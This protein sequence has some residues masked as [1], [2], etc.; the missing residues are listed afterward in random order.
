MATI[1]LYLDSRAKETD[2]SIKLA[3]THHGST[4]YIPTGIRVNKDQWDKAA[5]KIINHPRKTQL[6][7]IL[8]N[9]RYRATESLAT[10][11]TRVRVNSLTAT[12]LR[13]LVRDI[14][15][16]SGQQAEG[17]DTF[18]ARFLAYANRA[19]A[20]NT[21]ALYLQTY[22]RLQAYCPYLEDLAFEDITKQWIEEFE[23]FLAT[24][25]P[26]QN[27][28]NIHLRN[29]RTVFNDAIENEVTT[30]YPFRKI[31]IKPVATRHR[32]L[33]IAQLRRVWNAPATPTQQ[34]YLDAFKL[35]FLLRGINMADLCALTAIDRDGRVT[36][37]RAKTS[38]LISVLVEPEAMD[39]IRKYR[40]DNLLLNFTE[41]TTLVAFTHQLNRVL[42]QLVPGAPFNELTAYWARHTWATIA[43]S[44]DIPREVIAHALGH[45]SDYNSVTDVYI[46]YDERKTDQANRLVISHVL[47]E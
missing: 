9:K 41:G 20:A 39:I 16:G 3:I 42:K 31:H 2:I 33:T 1:K 25:S 19:K 27:A 38:G 17:S 18:A 10:I 44:L 36:Y 37:N 34:K 13:D 28:R 30:A 40:G 43:A 23:R 26:S 14:L 47:A 21:R 12:R 15:E 11:A 5:Q 46:R 29:I 7:A 6:N 32:A 24:T 45:R 22:R 8:L 35:S 4:V